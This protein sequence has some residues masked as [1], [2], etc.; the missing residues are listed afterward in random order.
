MPTM[1]PS[2]MLTERI[3]SL[4]R[5]RETDLLALKYQLHETGESQK[6]ANIVKSSVHVVAHNEQV[7]S[8]IKKALIGIAVG[9][10]AKM[11][12][13]KKKKKK[14]KPG[15]LMRAALS[16]GIN[17]LISNRYRLLKSAG[18]MALSALATNIINKRHNHQP[19]EDDPSS[20]ASDV[21][22]TTP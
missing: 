4:E 20:D 10:V 13:S 8:V 3:A 7:I 18:A 21:S 19:I 17:M 1:N 14:R 2:E 16:I 11:V 9:L 6:H 15:S 12:L 5:Q 22:Y